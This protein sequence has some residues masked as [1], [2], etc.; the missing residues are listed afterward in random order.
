MPPDVDVCERCY[1]PTELKSGPE[2]RAV[3]VA[4]AV[5]AVLLLGSWYGTSRYLARRAFQRQVLTLAQARAAV[6]R[7]LASANRSLAQGQ[8]LI[9]QRRYQEAGLEFADATRADPGNAMAWASLGAAKMLTGLTGDA[10]DCYDKALALEPGNWLAHYNLGLFSARRGDRE[11]ALGHLRQALAELPAASRKR[12]E[13]IRDLLAD[14][15]LEGIRQDPRFAGLL[16][17]EPAALARRLR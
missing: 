15:G 2:W 10:L 9:G 8:A 11:A 12:R 3:A 4:A 17:G 16:G 5:A 13:V 14:P 6:E 7:R 1:Q